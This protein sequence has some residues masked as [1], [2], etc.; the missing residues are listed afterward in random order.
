MTL[1]AALNLYW[2]VALSL[3]ALAVA[4]SRSEKNDEEMVYRVE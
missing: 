1:P 2:A 3:V 4:A